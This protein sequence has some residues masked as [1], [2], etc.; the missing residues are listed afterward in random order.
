MAPRAAGNTNEASDKVG[1]IC[2]ALRRA[3]IEQAL[4]PGAKLPEDSLGERFGV[5]R[6]IA[7]H[8]LGQLAAEGLVELRRNRIAVVATPSWQDARDAFDVRIQLERLVVRQLAGKL[9]RAQVAELNAHVDAEDR[10][11]GGSDPVSIRLATEFHILL[12][13]MTNSPIL[14]RYVSE[15]AYRCCL[16][17]SLYSRPHSSECAINEHRAIIA[18]L[19]RGDED[20]SVSLMHGHLDSVAS[21][22][23]VTPAPQRGRD[24]LD[25]L[26]P[27]ADEPDRGG[28]VK[29]PKAARGR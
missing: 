11:R 26:A 5:S 18:A 9:T 14:I 8:A 19:V 6:T 23:L 25:I 1:V 7:R 27:Y 15:I 2:R 10:A 17:L 28:V 12:A 16:T 21:R 13:H 4:E 24:L 29:L 3:I 20:K 22:A